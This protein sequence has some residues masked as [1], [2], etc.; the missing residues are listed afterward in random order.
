M[1]SLLAAG[2]DGDLALPAR[3]GAHC[4]GNF[5]SNRNR[6][7]SDRGLDLCGRNRNRSAPQVRGSSVVGDPRVLARCGSATVSLSAK[8]SPRHCAS[9]ETIPSPRTPLKAPHHYVRAS[10]Y[11]DGFLV[12]QAPIDLTLNNAMVGAKKEEGLIAGCSPAISLAT[13]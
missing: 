13:F 3:L 1:L 10:T 9:L 7:D 2:D 5:F 12:S 4:L 6:N 8:P 11:F